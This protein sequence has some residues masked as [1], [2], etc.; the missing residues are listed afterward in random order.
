MPAAPL[1]LL[2]DIGGTNARFALGAAD[3]TVSAV[4]RLPTA[5]H[6]SL[7]DAARHYLAETSAAP[8]LAA[9]AVAGPVTGDAV[10]LTNL[11]WQFSAAE[12]RDALGLERLL[13]LN[14]FEAQ[15]LA[16]P[17][18]DAAGLVQIG[19]GEIESRA[20]K[21]VLGPGTGLGVAGLLPDGNDGWMALPSEGG[22]V[23]MAAADD[24]EA[25]VLATLRREFGH[26]SA[27]R[28]ISGP[29]LVNL[30]RA[31]GGTAADEPAE[32]AARGLDGGDAI[33]AKALDIFQAM[34]GTVA[35][36]LALTLNARGGVY[37]AGGI[38][39]RL[40]ERFPA[41]PFRRRFEDKG[42]F[43][44]WLRAVPTFVVVH[45]EPAFV[46]LVRAAFD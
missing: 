18:L 8:Q 2:A 23:T 35:G 3:G 45:A 40:I 4:R 1:A 42:R 11:A 25:R 46:G 29:G 33:A 14:D 36:D 31:L 21:A 37:V 13:L 43:T 16:L 39:P 10:R 5:G 32:V 41:G 30:Y 38:V 44:E 22:H 28:V 15:A 26:V 9:F 24:D 19:R 34:L 6:P 7:V 20:P 27:E 17:H 12:V